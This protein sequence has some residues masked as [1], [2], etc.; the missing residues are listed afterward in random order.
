MTKALLIVDIQ[1]D[2]FPGGNMELV[3][4]VEAAAVAAL[5]KADF[6][7]QGLPV[8]VIQHVAKSPTATF[9]L[10]NT[11]GVEIHESV[12]PLDGDQVIVKHFPNS[13]RETVL[14]ENLREANIDE[15][16]IVGM[17]THMCIDTTTRAAND[18]GFK[19]ELIENACATRDLEHHGVTV[20][21]AQVQTAYLAALDGS[22]AKVV[23][24]PTSR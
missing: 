15:I 19:V 1:N 21:A 5:V 6:N 2:Y 12:A 17:M 18:L 14:L 22:F 4:S 7:E 9:F 11:S 3:G 24:W 13:F 10:P 20:S 23:S 8:F 16:T